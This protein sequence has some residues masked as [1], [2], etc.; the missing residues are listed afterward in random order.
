MKKKGHRPVT[1]VK[2][3][4][5]K[6]EDPNWVI[7]A[8]W[9][10]RITF[11]EIEKKTGYRESDVIKIMRR[12]LKPSSFRLWRK[13]VHEKSIK[14][15]KKFEY[16]RK[17]ITSKIKKT[18]HLLGYART[19]YHCKNCGGHHGHIFEDGPQPTGK[20]YCNNG[21]CLVFEPKSKQ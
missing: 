17:Q 13:R 1:R 12:S 15:R 3:P 14:H 9:A 6:I 16:S 21:V 19:E 4:E 10:D 11:E 5:P 8:A 18:D 2:N 7:W 20:R